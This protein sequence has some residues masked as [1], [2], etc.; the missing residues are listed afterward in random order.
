MHCWFWKCGIL[1]FFRA[2]YI[3]GLFK[4]YFEG[5]KTFLTPKLSRAAKFRQNY[6]PLA[7]LSC[8]AVHFLCMVIL[9]YRL[10]PR[11]LFK[12][13][14][15][16][17]FGGLEF[18]GHSFAYVAHLWFLRDV[19]IQTQS[20]AV[21]SWRT[22]GR[23][24]MLFFI[25]VRIRV[26]AFPGAKNGGQGQVMEVILEHWSAMGHRDSPWIPKCLFLSNRLTVCPSSLYL[27]WTGSP[28]SPMV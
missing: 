12:L 27:S 4:G 2:N 3:M 26:N 10:P 18:V 13:F 1:F 8:P 28:K 7:V 11:R 16:I 19:W 22:W 14:F 5:A 9:P 6:G 20:T 23:H 25:A 17:F 15:C 21:A 24:S